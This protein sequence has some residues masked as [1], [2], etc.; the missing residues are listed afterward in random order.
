M[1]LKT[2][3]FAY[4]PRAS[5]SRFTFCWW[6]HNQLAMTSQW[7]DNC[8]ANTW[9][10]ISNS[11]DI[12]FIHSDIHGRSCKKSPLLLVLFIILLYIFMYITLVMNFTHMAAVAYPLMYAKIWHLV[13][14]PILDKL[15]LPCFAKVNYLYMTSVESSHVIC[16]YLFLE[17]RHDDVIKWKYFPRYWPFMQGIHRSQRPVTRSFD[18][19]FYLRLNKRLSKQSSGWW[20]ETRSCPL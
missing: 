6:R 5:L 9:Q 18:V 11:L 12:D 16:G 15:S 7:P 14:F 17:A 2:R 20:F 1:T 3:I 4:H 19:F 13:S 8:D 10:V